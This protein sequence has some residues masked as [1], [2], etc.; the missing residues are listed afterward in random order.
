M[1][2][3]DGYMLQTCFHCGN[4][5]LLKI[6][7]QYDY[8]VGGWVYDDFGREIGRDL[9]ED[10]IWTML[11]CPVCHNVTLYETYSNE[12]YENPYTNIQSYDTKVLYPK[13]TLDYQGVPDN[14]KT[15]FESALKVKNIDTAI[16]L[17]SLR[18]VLEA[19]CKERG[20]EGDNLYH[21]VADL[22]EKGKLPPMF[23]DACWIVRELGNAAAH[24][25]KKVFYLHHVEQTIE[26]VETMI[27]DL[28]SLPVKVKALKERVEE[29]KSAKE[30]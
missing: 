9:Q 5:G 3:P 14:I 11:S 17:L 8:S 26:F 1:S 25:D 7:K 16:C 22:I 30:V 6:E 18:R 13:S 28:Y 12:T 4:Q 19:I 29:E 2:I 10:Y 23:A 27:N 21:M 15:A 20:A 24:A